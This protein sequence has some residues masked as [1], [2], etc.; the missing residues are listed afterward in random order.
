[1]ADELT[2]PEQIENED[3]ARAEALEPQSAGHTW[4]ESLAETFNPFEYLFEEPSAGL[5]LLVLSAGVVAILF[6]AGGLWSALQEAL[7]GG[8]PPQG[9]GL[10]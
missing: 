1:M 10:K 8:G 5:V 9:L 2:S 6:L 7:F 3:H 4:I